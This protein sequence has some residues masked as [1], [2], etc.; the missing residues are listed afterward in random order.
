MSQCS[1]RQGPAALDLADH[2]AGLDT[3]D[4]GNVG[5]DLVQIM[6]VVAHGRDMHDQEI[7]MRSGDQIAAHHLR[8]SL[9]RL[10]ETIDVL[11]AAAFQLDEH[12]EREIEAA[13]LGIDN[14]RIAL[15][16]PILL[17]PA[18]P[19]SRRCW[20]ETDDISN[21]LDACAPVK[22]QR[23]EDLSIQLIQFM[24]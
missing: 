13:G 9:D 22:L 7:V 16:R 12:V 11:A 2:D 14:R 8:Q 17:E 15:D 24:S 10:L 21:L 20:R 19:A 5:D 18:D 23:G 1:E 4:A 3:D 6:V